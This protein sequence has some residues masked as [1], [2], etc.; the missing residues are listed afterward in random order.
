MYRQCRRRVRRSV[1]QHTGSFAPDGDGAH[2][3]FCGV[4][5][6]FQDALIEVGPQP[7]HA[8]Q[9]IVDGPSQRRFSRDTEQL[10]VQPNFQI[11]EDRL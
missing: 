9:S 2:R 3:A 11:V 7:R 10:G 6:E 1:I 5:V 8:R 4:V